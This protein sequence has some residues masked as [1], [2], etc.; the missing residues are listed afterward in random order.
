MEPDSDPVLD[1]SFD[2]FDV[3]NKIQQSITNQQPIAIEKNIFLGDIYM[4]KGE[5]CHEFGFDMDP[6][7]S[8]M[9]TVSNIRT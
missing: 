6:I 1:T 7:I 8:D 3:G 5:E 2:W 4:N 9:F